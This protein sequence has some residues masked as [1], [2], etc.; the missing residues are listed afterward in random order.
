MANM[1]I[2]TKD[3][4][5][6]FA[7]SKIGFGHSKEYISGEEYYVFQYS[8]DLAKLISTNFSNTDFL[9]SNRICF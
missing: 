7:L 5:V 9:F 1:L 4:D 8:N 6:A 3:K 2:K